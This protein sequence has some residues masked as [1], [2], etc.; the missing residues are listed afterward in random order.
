MVQGYPILT[1][2]KSVDDV[3]KKWRGRWLGKTAPRHSGPVWH[4]ELRES[5]DHHHDLGW[6]DD[7]ASAH[8]ALYAAEQVLKVVGA[9]V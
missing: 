1:R 3:P 7:D 8:A 2:Y 6:F 4:L 9:Y 5:I